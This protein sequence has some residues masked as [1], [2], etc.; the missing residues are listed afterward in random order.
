MTVSS[1]LTHN[2]ATC[3]LQCIII[4]DAWLVFFKQTI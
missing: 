1:I 4:Y 2:I 3:I